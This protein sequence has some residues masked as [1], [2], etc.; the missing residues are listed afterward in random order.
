MIVSVGFFGGFSQIVL[1]RLMMFLSILQ[2]IDFIALPA[3]FSLI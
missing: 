2:S 3:Y 1:V